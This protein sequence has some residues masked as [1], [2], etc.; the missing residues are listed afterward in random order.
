MQ[1]S[2]P[3][4]RA[5]HV[6][7]LLRPA[8]VRA[9]RAEAAS[10]AMDPALLRRIED[11]AIRDV[12]AKQEAAGLASITDG[13]FR[14]RWFHIDFLEQIEGIEAQ[15]SGVASGEE[16]ET[17]PPKLVVTGKLR[18]RKPI[19]GADFDFLK[20]AT[21]Q[22]AKVTIPSPSMAHFRAGR[23]GVSHEAYPDIEEF[24]ADLAGAYRAEIADLAQRG[25]RYIQ[26]DDTNLAYLC[27]EKFRQNARAMGEDPTKLPGV[28]ARLINACI[29]DA[30]DDMVFAIHL[31][32]GNFR[33]AFVAEGGY[34]PVAETLFG[35][36][37]VDAFFLEY[38]DARSGG[39][40]PLRFVPKGKTV[41]LGVVSSKTPQL[42][43]KD[44][45]KRRID[46]AAR[47]VPL[48]QLGLSPQCG[49]SS[50]EHGNDLSEADQWAKLRLVVETAAEVWG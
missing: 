25:C 29:R 46:S 41:V 38:D 22:T 31:C 44:A 12:V 9:A 47:I 30:P 14:R 3:P 6:G 13:E 28:Y 39:F 21:K 11:A 42:E 15:Y 18:R 32:R 5:D 26:L 20:R 19:M 35:E 8:G 24:F 43:S 45:I 10:G 2:S 16:L 27:D 49:F 17:T 7:S 50:T 48:E 37:D 23:A 4:F 36:I 40:E 1:Q 33:S 34:D